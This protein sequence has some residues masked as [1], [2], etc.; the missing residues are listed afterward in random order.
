V[1]ELNRA[2][3]AEPGDSVEESGEGDEFP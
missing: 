2:E 3:A 1:R